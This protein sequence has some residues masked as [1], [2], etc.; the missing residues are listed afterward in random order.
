MCLTAPEKA[1]VATWLERECAITTATSIKAV[2][3]GT[4]TIDFAFG[5]NS[6]ISTEALDYHFGG[7]VQRAAPKLKWY[8]ILAIVVLVLSFL[9]VSTVG[10]LVLRFRKENGLYDD[11]S[12][13][14][15]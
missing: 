8:E 14:R 6:P 3:E 9:F 1:A 7:V 4:F 13:K 11:M 10:F 5:T 12:F 2:E 15:K